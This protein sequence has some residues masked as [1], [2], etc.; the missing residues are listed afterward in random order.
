MFF[1]ACIVYKLCNGKIVY[2]GSVRLSHQSNLC[3]KSPGTLKL[4]IA[5]VVPYIYPICIFS[6]ITPETLKW[7]IF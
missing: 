2:Q 7:L 1:Q 4:N 6:Y 5:L 3:T